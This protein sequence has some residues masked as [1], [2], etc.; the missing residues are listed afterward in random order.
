MKANDN[1]SLPVYERVP[2]I[3]DPST[4]TTNKNTCPGLATSPSATLIKCDFYGK[5]I[6]PNMA[7]N[8]GQSE[9]DF[10]FVKAGSNAYIKSSA[11]TVDGY[12]GPNS[13]GTAAISA[14]APVGAHGYIRS[15][16]FQINIPYDPAVC[17]RAC[18]AS[19][20]FNSAHGRAPCVFFDA[21]VQYLNGADG[22]MT[23]NLYSV[24]YDAS[25]AT[26]VGRHDNSGNHWTIAFSNGYTKTG[27][28][29]PS[30][31]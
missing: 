11:P 10:K 3:V 9:Q 30:I 8:I 14:P 15:Q 20:E 16:T 18:D 21:F 23:C 13:F 28:T 6:F 29:G 27:Y 5:P 1:M 12:D 25:Y 26:N 24:E 2:L 17:G 31:K 19:A 22:V 4:H 7:T